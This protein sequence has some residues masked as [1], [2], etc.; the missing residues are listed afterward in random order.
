M[1]LTLKFGLYNPPR[2]ANWWDDITKF[3]SLVLYKGKKWEFVIYD[4]DPS[5]ETAWIC[6]FSEIAMHDTNWYS[7]DYVDIDHLLHN[8]SGCD[9][10]AQYTSFS[11]DHMRF[12]PKWSKW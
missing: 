9:C 5:G 6:I 12:C 7:M 11:W 10:G 4:H 1:K 8:V 2:M 3:P